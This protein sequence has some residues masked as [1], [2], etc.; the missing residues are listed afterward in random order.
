MAWAAAAGGLMQSG[1]IVKPMVQAYQQRRENEK[2]RQ[3]EARI[4]EQERLNQERFAKEGIRWKVADAK[5]AGIHPLY[6]LGA[7]TMSYTP[8]SQPLASTP[9]NSISDAI[10]RVGQNTGRAA[11]AAIT[12]NEQV[13]QQQLKQNQLQIENSE[14]QNMKLRSEIV[15]MNQNRGQG[16]PMT[17]SNS[18][19]PGQTN[20][21]GL[22]KV[23]PAERTVSQP[24]SRGQEAGSVND[25]SYI[26]TPT[27]LSIA[28]SKDV[29]E[30]IE[31][32]LI[33]ELAWAYRNHFIP[34]FRGHKP[35]DPKEYPLPAGYDRWE[36]NAW[37][38]EFQPAKGPAGNNWL[39][40]PFKDWR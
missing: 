16:M 39:T 19:I 32:Q 4:A 31:D 29:K 25:Y 27:G 20:S 5:A 14:L 1:G 3:N 7:N 23:N 17:T 33:P 8:V 28:P 13:E 18:F 21:S 26:E 38:Q 15:L 22:V 11:A 36:W 35:P 34:A 9:D 10:G 2:A 6:A 40:R 37:K 12:Q 30:R 24:G